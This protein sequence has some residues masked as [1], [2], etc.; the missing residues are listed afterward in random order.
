ML[1]ELRLSNT[2]KYKRSSLAVMTNGAN[3][4]IIRR[5]DT[6][7]K[8]QCYNNDGASFPRRKIPQICIQHSTSM[9]IEDKHNIAT[10]ETVIYF[11]LAASSSSFCS[12]K[13]TSVS[14]RGANY[15]PWQYELCGHPRASRWREQCEESCMLRRSALRR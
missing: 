7:E 14:E 5:V 1:R 9:G 11:F 13:L 2:F 8:E 6:V 15:E 3:P 4:S 12:R 10:R